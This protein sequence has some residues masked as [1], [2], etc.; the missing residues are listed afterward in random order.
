MKTTTRVRGAAVLL[1][2][3]ALALGACRDATAPPVP[4]NV[5]VTPGV[6]TFDALGASQAVTAAVVDQHGK[7]M[8]GVP[9]SWTVT[10]A[11]ATV[12]PSG[13]QGATVTAAAGGSA[14]VTA[15]AGGAATQLLVQVA[16][17][18]T[19]VERV[20]G[21][22]QEGVAGSTLER[23]LRVVVRDRLGAGVPGVLVTYTVAHGGGSLSGATVTSGPLGAA[24]VS[25]TLGT[26][27]AS[28]Q[29]V[30]AT[31]QGVS[32]AAR[33]TAVA[34]A[35]APASLAVYG[36]NAQSAAAGARLPVNPTV[37]VADAFDNPVSGVTVT[38]A[39]VSGGGEIEGATA[40][41]GA[42]GRAAVGSWRLGPVGPQS[43]RANAPGLPPLLFSAAALGPGDRPRLFIS[44][45]DNQ[46]AMVSSAVPFAPAV[47][48][49]DGLGNPLP[50]VRVTFTVVGGAG[51][52]SGGSVAADAAGVATAGG[53]EL[54]PLAGPNTVR[55]TLEQDPAVSI[56]LVAVG[57]SGGGGSGYAIT[58]CF[59]TALPA[60]AR[61]AFETAAARWSAVI[62]GDLPAVPLSSNP[63]TCGIRSPRVNFTADDLVILVMVEEIDG[64]GFVL[65]SA[66]PCFIRSGSSL[67]ALGRMRLDVADVEQLQARGI[68]GDVILHEMGHVIGIGTL[69]NVFSLLQLPSTSQSALDTHYTGVGGR[70]GFEAVGGASYAAGQKVPVENTGGTGTMNGHWRETVL[71]NELMTGYI[72]WGANPMSALTIRSLEDLGYQVDA[73]AADAYS[74]TTA[75]G[76][77]AD[78]HAHPRTRLVDDIDT[79]PLYEVDGKGRTRRIR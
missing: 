6:V 52:I 65:G 50:G 69:W 76:V 24:S 67:P 42:E 29:E 7:P 25:W 23:P 35:G 78:A 60:A 13:A 43:L 59:T 56:D 5:T 17:V 58:L 8:P 22:A 37:R 68:L 14:T 66:S 79:G 32:D 26:N 77:A 44:T 28:L 4:T 54:G 63:G 16:Q 27:A 3:L 30:L 39:V 46:A 64:P 53:W 36:G 70:A 15:T 38:F 47:T 31:A 21:D 20:E 71:G 11:A 1:P 9:V 51:R 75:A 45:G 34:R 73:A 72:N 74:L 40:V 49:R 10:G 12:A 2:L 18:P 33:F 19:T 57:C 48:V 41:T 55:A 62:T 61:A